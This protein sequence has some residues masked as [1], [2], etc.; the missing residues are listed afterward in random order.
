MLKKFIAACFVI[1]GIFVISIMYEG[2]KAQMDDQARHAQLE[3]KERPQVLKNL[4]R[5]DV[6]KACIRH[7][8]WDAEACQAMDQQNVS[9]G[10]T[11]EQVQLAW[12]KPQRINNTIF[13]GRE[14]Q[15]WV[16]GV[17]DYL[18]IEDGVLR[19]IQTSQ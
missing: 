6:R 5:S 19:S 16:Y 3:Q 17:G 12:G 2:S 10:M 13:S 18:Y 15:Q 1:M 14:R 9:I 8:E 4:K 7:T 11:A